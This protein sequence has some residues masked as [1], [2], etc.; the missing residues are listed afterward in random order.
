MKRENGFYWILL[1][2]WVVAEF[3]TGLWHYQGGSF[4]D[5]GCRIINEQKL[6]EPKDY[7][8]PKTE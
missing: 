4:N 5:M 7:F 3:D 8:T 2:R 6:I 1:N